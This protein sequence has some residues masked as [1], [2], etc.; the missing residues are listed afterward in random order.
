MVYECED[1]LIENYADVTTPYTSAI[2]TG[3]V[4]AKLQSTS[5]MLFLLGSKITIWKPTLKNVISW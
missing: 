2:D 1:F 3:T 4:I 5:D